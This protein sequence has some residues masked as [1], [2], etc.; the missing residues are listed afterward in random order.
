[1]LKK[2]KNLVVGKLFKN[3]TTSWLTDL[4]KDEKLQK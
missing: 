4:R 1:M 2:K 3:P